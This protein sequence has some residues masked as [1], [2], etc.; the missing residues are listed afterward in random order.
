[1]IHSI[2][3]TV[4]NIVISFYSD[5]WVLD[6]TCGDHFIR[7]INVSLSCTLETDMLSTVLEEKKIKH[8]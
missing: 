1:M 2:G 3:N 7:Y 4:N 6:L 5:R 8:F